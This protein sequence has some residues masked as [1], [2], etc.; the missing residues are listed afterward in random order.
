MRLVIFLLVSAAALWTSFAI[1]D[2]ILLF[3][4]VIYLGYPSLA[5]TFV[6]FGFSLYG[7][8]RQTGV[9]RE[10][11]PRGKI[12]WAA[13]AFVAGLLLLCEPF[14][15]KVLNDE[16][17]LTSTA[18]ML[19]FDRLAGLPS[20]ANDLS[21]SYLLLDAILDKRPLFF[22]F[23][24]SLVHDLTGYRY[25]NVFI[26]NGLLTVVLCVLLYGTGRSLSNHRG[27][28]LTVLLA[29]TLPLLG[30]FA[31]SGHFEVLNLVMI[32]LVLWLSYHYIRKPGEK[33]MV[34][35]VYALVLLVQV[36]YENALYLLPFGILL[37]LG[38]KKAGRIL[39]PW[40]VIVAPV[41]FIL[42]AMNYRLI[43]NESNNAFQDGPN[44]RTDTFSLDYIGENLTS[45]GD[46][47][48]HIGF[49]FSNSYLLTVLGFTSLF[50]F[51]WYALKRS[52]RLTGADPK[53]T[54]M[55]FFL[56]SVVMF[57]MV[58]VVFN[59][60]LFSI[61]ITNRLSFPIQ[62]LFIM[63]TPFV[64]TRM[65]KRFITGFLFVLLFCGVF[66]TYLMLASEIIATG[67]QY[68]LAMAGGS[69][70]LYGIRVKSRNPVL[71]FALVPLVYILTIGLPTMHSKH[72]SHN[73]KSNKVVAHALKF[74]EDQSE[75]EKLFWISSSPFEGILTRNNTAPLANFK[76]APEELWR[77]ALQRNCN[78]VYIPRLFK[79]GP[80]GTYGVREE[81]EY[82][83]PRRFRTKTVFE[84]AVD[85]GII[86]RIDRLEEV[87]AAEEVNAPAEAPG[88]EGP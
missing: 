79:L 41:F 38:W 61:Y 52:R 71:G 6:L 20:A 10:L 7:L 83:D 70:L 81:K 33:A 11:L 62:L 40:Q 15:F 43:L 12:A 63:V 18:Q 35:L 72:Y 39:L 5:L 13:I 34:A 67:I 49:E 17:L 58:I 37:L 14:W 36:R 30:V 22:P 26:L 29:G 55:F 46:Y 27:G 19:H 59:F 84:R 88:T 51:C 64:V 75:V 1:A 82:L 3:R 77:Y 9:H 2:N 28:L 32:C 68:G 86:L 21:G 85:R 76:R 87:V 53:A 8:G 4:I 78:S 42:F 16:L 57:S 80:D 50:V 31:T 48:F 44:G 54:V 24:I 69:G 60:G 47:L 56:M 66:A 65:G 73:Y 25:E 74:I 45:A 23:L